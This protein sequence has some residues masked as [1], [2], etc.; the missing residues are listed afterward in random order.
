MKRFV[1]ATASALLLLAGS[2]AASVPGK[3]TTSRLAHDYSFSSTANG[4]PGVGNAAP[5]GLAPLQTN[6]LNKKTARSEAFDEASPRW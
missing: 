1:I 4:G 5:A 2:A 6:R 3:G